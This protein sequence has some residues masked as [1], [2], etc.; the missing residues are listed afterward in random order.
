MI[1]NSRIK[2]MCS[3][4]SATKASVSIAAI[5]AIMC[6]PVFAQSETLRGGAYGGD[7]IIV[8]ARKRDEAIEDVPSSVT[9]LSF[10]AIEDLIMEDVADIVRQIPGGILIA[11]GPDYLDDIALRGQGGGRLGVSESTT[12]IYKDGMFIAGGG[13]GGRSYSRIDLFDLDRVE[14]YRGPQGAL[15]GRNAV[16]GAINVLTKAPEDGFGG[17]LK[18][19][20]NSVE[21][22]NIEGVVNAPLVADK[23]NI[24]IGGYYSEQ[25]DGFYTD[26]ATG[27]AIDLYEDWGMRGSL[28]AALGADTNV[29]LAVEHSRSEAPGFGT[30]GQNLT[31]DPDPFTR[32]G[33]SDFDTVIIEQTSVSGRLTH[34]FSG[35]ELTILGNYKTRDGDRINGDL[36]HFIGFNSPALRLLDTLTE[37][38]SRHGV[39]VRLTSVNDGPLTWLA[40][41]DYQG[42]QSDNF[43]ERTGTL[44]GPFGLSAALRALL[45]T[46]ISTEELSSYSFFGLLGYDLTD[47]LNLTVEARVQVDDKDFLF[48]RMDPDPLTDETIAPT[49]FDEKSTRFLPTASLAYELSDDASIYARV[50]TGYRPGGFNPFPTVGFFNQTAYDPEDIVSYEAGVKGSFQ[51]G[52]VTIRPQLAVYYSETDD[53]QSVTNLSATNSIFSLQNVGGNNVYG[54]EFELQAYTPLWGGEFFTNLG[55]SATDGEFDEGTDILFL[56]STIDLSGLRVPRTRDYIIN[57]HTGYSH[58]IGRSVDGFIS[59]SFQ[60]EGG[61]FDNATN[62]RESEGYEIIDLSAG[63]RGEHWRLDGYVKNLTDDVYRLVEVNNNNFY[64]AP[65]SYG[66]RLSADW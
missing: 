27:E 38:F 44:L 31:L 51:S 17:F 39:E 20:Y 52:D 28:G 66:V 33:L 7:Q 63:L 43:T 15:Y 34:A 21:R 36:D 23:L 29:I 8:Q 4:K 14:V 46:D 32:I 12:G 16:G 9:A 47:R 1:V 40:G 59:F 24:R 11:S 22:Y 42:F 58:P 5:A 60:A 18:A 54:F 25:N 37:D 50:A 6:T 55:A 19:G 56:G 53:V 10:D 61:G 13:F 48:E 64:N 3:I 41:A 26:D 30:L 35:A 2:P 45:R 57:V 65:R 49:T 62:T